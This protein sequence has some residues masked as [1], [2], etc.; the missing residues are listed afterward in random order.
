MIRTLI[1]FMVFASMMTTVTASLIPPMLHRGDTVALISSAFRIANNHS[2]F[3]ARKR[4]K[5]LGLKTITGKAVLGHD[6]YF[7]GSDQARADDINRLFANP[8][9]KAIFELRGGWGS[10]RILPLL[11]YQL[12]KRHPKIF[13]GYSDI[14]S[15]LLAIHDKTGL[16]T[17]HGPMPGYIKYWSDYSAKEL[18]RMLFNRRP[19]TLKNPPHAKII[20]IT[21]GIASGTLIGG[22]LSVLVSLIGTPYMSKDWH[23]KILFIEDTYEDVYQVD[24][25]LTHLALAGILQQL[26]GFVFGTCS[27]CTRLIPG[28]VTML[29]VIKQHIQPLGIPAFYGAEFGHQ[30]NMYT[31]PVGAKVS[32]NAGRGTI[33]LLQQVVK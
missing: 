13:V 23:H 22:N 24:R 33:K 25:M 12:I 31:L 26:S 20:T 8:K 4:L 1:F 3:E 10:A 28:S 17:F 6:G 5:A 19:M 14:T 9:V 11:N 18:K 32:I 2:L 15:L 27:H 29:Q 16:V 7:A 21:P 30:A